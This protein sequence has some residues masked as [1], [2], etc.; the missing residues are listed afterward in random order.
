MSLAESYKHPACSIEK[1][2]MEDMFDYEEIWRD[3][4]QLHYTLFEYSTTIYDEMALLSQEEGDKNEALSDELRKIINEL[5]KAMKDTS[6]E[7]NRIDKEKYDN[8]AQYSQKRANLITKNIQHCTKGIEEFA[9]QAKRA[10]TMLLM[11][12]LADGASSAALTNALYLLLLYRGYLEV[13]VPPYTPK[14]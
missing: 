4:N 3:L 11:Q 8:H 14:W 6:Q 9:P 13:F 5:S 7:D 1:F 2:K 10:D 12:P